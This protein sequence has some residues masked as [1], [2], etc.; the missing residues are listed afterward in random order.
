MDLKELV[1]SYHGKRVKRGP[2]WKWGNQGNYGESGIVDVEGYE[3]SETWAWIYVKWDDGLT[4]C[5]RIGGEYSDVILVE[6]EFSVNRF[7]NLKEKNIQPGR[8]NC[9]YCG[10]KLKNPIPGLDIFKHCPT[11]EP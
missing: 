5:Y 2:T 9:D 11:C 10:G 6:E 3:I 7:G 1:E 8:T 4:G